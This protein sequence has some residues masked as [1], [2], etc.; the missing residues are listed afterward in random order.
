MLSIITFKNFGIRK[1]YSFCV[2]LSS[3]YLNFNRLCRDFGAT[4]FIRVEYVKYF[5]FTILFK[6][7][8]IINE[9]SNFLK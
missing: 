7:L 1:F 5:I 9:Q 6:Y 8:F 4:I 2:K 3:N